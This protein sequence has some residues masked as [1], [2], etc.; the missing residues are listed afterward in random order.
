MPKKVN[1][2][3]PSL[4]YIRIKAMVNLD[5]TVIYVYSDFLY[6]LAENKTFC[7]CNKQIRMPMLYF[8]V[9]Q[10]LGYS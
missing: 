7:M 5:T 4:P 3:C 1:N 6:F 2:A 8:V 9:I 10:S